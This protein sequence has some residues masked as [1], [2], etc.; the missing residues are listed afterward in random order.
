MLIEWVLVMYVELDDESLVSNYAVLL[1]EKKD[2]EG[3]SQVL[4]AALVIVEE[5]NLEVDSKFRVLV[6]IGSLDG[7][8]DGDSAVDIYSPGAQ[9]LSSDDMQ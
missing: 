8:G 7:D 2:Q 6:A 4:S 3:Q 1:I 5:E 9:R